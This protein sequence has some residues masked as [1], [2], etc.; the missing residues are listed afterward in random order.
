MDFPGKLRLQQCS[1]VRQA[2]LFLLVPHGLLH[3]VEDSF[4]TDE[5]WTYLVQATGLERRLLVLHRFTAESPLSESCIVAHRALYNSWSFLHVG[6]TDTGSD[7]C[8]PALKLWH[9]Y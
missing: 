9:H 8:F 3:F 2:Q 4:H 7:M 5:G 6:S 1:C